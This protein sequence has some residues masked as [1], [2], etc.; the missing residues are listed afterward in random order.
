MVKYQDYY[1]VLGVPRDA[2]AK[3]IKTA[4]RKLAR[5]YHP[6]ANPGSKDA[7]EKFKEITEAYEVLKDPDKRKRYDMLGS[8]W[9]AGA[10]F[11]PPPGYG[12]GT[13]GFTFDFGDLAGMSGGMGGGNSAFSDF[14]ETL[15]GQAFSQDA[16]G[17][18]PS[19]TAGFRNRR[20]L[21]QEAEIELTIEEVAKGTTRTLQVSGPG[22][23]AK[24]L[25]VK[26]PAGVRNGS[27]VRVP[28]EGAQAA[29]GG[30]RG[31]LYLRVK[32]KPHPIFN[33]DGDNII[34]ELSLSPVQAVLGTES[35]VQTLDGLVKVTIPAGSQTGRSLR[36]RGK[37]LPRLKQD[38]RGDH[39]VKLKVVIPASLSDKERPLWEQLSKLEQEQNKT[40]V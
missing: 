40:K 17:R 27:K 26:I 7:E 34:T 38:V 1:Q 9:K 12:G 18:G 21:D 2:A 23:K 29:N 39:L 25:E 33:I 13:G 3:D 37:G 6:D 8:N 32:I 24:T 14:F 4:Y 15:F 31:D 11:T 35:T 22:V 10:D 28:G 30:P 20:E 36:L 16:R 19:S 5:Q